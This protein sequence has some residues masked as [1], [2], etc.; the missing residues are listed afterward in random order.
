MGLSPLRWTW[1]SLHVLLSIAFFAQLT[2]LA[3]FALLALAISDARGYAA[4]LWARS[5]ITTHQAFA[6][7]LAVAIVFYT[8]AVTCLVDIGEPRQRRSTDALFV[9]ACV[10]GIG[11]WRNARAALNRDPSSPDGDH[12]SA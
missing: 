11:L 5:R 6:F 3:G 1:I 10:L 2:A 4:A 9:F 12:T 7:G 8:M